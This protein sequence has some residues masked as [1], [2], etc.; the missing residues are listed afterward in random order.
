MGFRDPAF[1]DACLSFS[2]T[3]DSMVVKSSK[4]A[5]FACEVKLRCCQGGSSSLRRSREG[6]EGPSPSCLDAYMSMKRSW[7]LL[8]TQAL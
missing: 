8:K 7:V 1:K 6:M 5:A 3:T 4:E 2:A